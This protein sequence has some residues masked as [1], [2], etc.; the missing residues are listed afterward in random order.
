[1]DFVA[2]G[3]EGNDDGVK[4]LEKLNCT[5][6]P[7]RVQVLVGDDEESTTALLKLMVRSLSPTSGQIMLDG[8]PL[9]DYDPA[10]LS[11]AIQYIGH[12]PEFFDLSLVDNLQLANPQATKQ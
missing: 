10:T 2:G 1:M 6:T 5:F 11:G 12:R 7:D 8:R 9:E 4:V 3:V